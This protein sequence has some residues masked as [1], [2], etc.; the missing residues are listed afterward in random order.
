M[1]RSTPW[2]SIGLLALI[3]TATASTASA[4]EISFQRQVRG[5]LSDKCF[6][7]HGPDAGNRQAGLRLDEEAAAKAKLESGETAIVAGDPKHSAL[8][9]RIT[10]DDADLKMPPTDSNKSLTAAEVEILKQWVAEGANWGQHWSFVPVTRPAP[11]TVGPQDGVVNDIDRFVRARLPGKGLRPNSPADRVSLM[12]RVSLD[13]TGLPPT[14]AEVEDFVNDGSPNAYEKVVDRLL[15][16]PHYGENSARYWLDGARYGDTHGLH[17]DNY[18]EM[19]AYRDWVIDAYNSNKPF[20]VFTIEQLAGDLLD[21][22]SDDQLVATGFNRCHVTTSEGGSIAEEVHVRNVVDR[23]VTTGTVFMGLTMDCTRCHDHKFDPLTM[24]DFYSLYAYFNSIDGKPLDGNKKDPAP[25]LKVLTDEQKQQLAKLDSTHQSAQTELK[26]YLAS[27]NYEEPKT[28]SE[29][30]R[31]P[32]KELVWIDDA[33]PDGANAQGNSPWKFV[34]APAPVYSGELSSTRSAEGLSQHFFDA[35]TKPLTISDGASFFCYVYLD[36][37]NPPKEIMLQW[38]DGD[39]SQRAY[40]GGNH[41]DWGTD[42]SVSR[43]RMGDLP[44]TGEWVRLDVPVA[45]VGFKAGDKVQGWAFT[46]FDGTVYWD[47]AGILSASSKPV[48]YDSFAFWDR[49]QKAN[50]AKALPENLRPIALK[51][52]AERTPEETSQLKQHFLEFAFVTSHERVLALKE[53]AES[54]KNKAAGIRNAAPTTLVFREAPELKP[55]FIL[56]RGE[57][58]QQGDPVARATPAVL[59]DIPKELPNNRLGL[60]KW[61]TSEEHPLMSR[62]TVNRIWQQF[63]GT[64]LVKTTEDFGSQGEQ[65]THP[66]LLDWLASEFRKPQ[67]AG[68]AHDWDVKHLVK[69][70]VMSAT[71]RQTAQVLPNEYEVDPANRYLARGP[72]FRLDAEVLRDQAL[73]VSGLLVPDVGG[74]SVKPPQPDGLWFAVGYSG[75]NTV[76]FKQDEGHNKVHRRTL[77]TFIKRTAPPPQ[78]ST[79]D[80]PS[81][82]SCVVRRERT[83]SP[84]QALL[85][86][87]DPQYVECARA[88]AQRA[89]TEI[90][91]APADRARFILRQCVLRSPTDAEVQA[92]VTDYDHYLADFKQ[93]PDAAKKLVAIGE[94][95]PNAK[96]PVEELA[97]WTLVSNLVLNLDEVIN[98]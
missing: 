79:F 21:N 86:M 2:N 77:Y 35:A 14:V 97:A 89:M 93:S 16:S 64:G 59:P 74:P 71:Y 50:E 46:Q 82:E 87:N 11:P 34:K 51:P 32:P 20:N 31:E 62:V 4:E 78:M 44:K 30:V 52:A 69:L 68:A 80:A 42:K 38:N 15:K 55:A 29:P 19:W 25:V 45:E 5:I 49:D 91:S 47:K 57:Y 43:K 58:D 75:S 96:L 10:T 7:C 56:T 53:Q 73:G 18:R 24:T 94:V 84:L 26:N 81:R 95:P 70:I 28:P 37:K 90:G 12:R 6:Q 61:L 92:L 67:V 9:D 13:L 65:P 40:W 98:K 23:T 33:V 66:L 36:P 8:I 60:A 76:R 72:R 27:L 17:L 3:F 48:L 39:W 83:N 85:M 54:A 22:P 63:F 41:I 1:N 88:L